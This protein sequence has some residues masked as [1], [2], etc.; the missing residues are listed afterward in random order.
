VRPGRLTGLPREHWRERGSQGRARFE[1]G[2][3]AEVA[4]RGCLVAG[5]EKGAPSGG[6]AGVGSVL[7]ATGERDGEKKEGENNEPLST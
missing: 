6:A 2:G 5:S 7:V 4:G 3:A 1:E